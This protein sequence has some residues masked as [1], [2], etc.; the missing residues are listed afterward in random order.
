M[1][2]YAFFKICQ[3]EKK[4]KRKKK[5][6]KT[7]NLLFE[8]TYSATWFTWFASLYTFSSVLKSQLCFDD[9]RQI[10]KHRSLKETVWCFVCL[11]FL[12]K[13]QVWKNNLLGLLNFDFSFWTLL[14]FRK[15]WCFISWIN[16]FK[17]F[18]SVIKVSN[19][20]SHPFQFSNPSYVSLFLRFRSN[21]I[22]RQFQFQGFRSSSLDFLSNSFRSNRLYISEK[23]WSIQCEA[24]QCVSHHSIWIDSSRARIALKRVNTIGN[25]RN[26]NNCI[27]YDCNKSLYYDFVWFFFSSLLQIP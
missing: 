18:L 20:A 15:F 17:H 7:S 4:K 16:T 19:V 27:E 10:T 1:K 2:K 9:I 24:F 13:F 23:K 12:W 11:N 14:M 21:L 8:K 22:K 6:Q 5:T 26:K 25:H 3:I